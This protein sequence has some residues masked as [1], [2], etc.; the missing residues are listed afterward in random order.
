M[1]YCYFSEFLLSKVNNAGVFYSIPH[2]KKNRASQK[3]KH[4]A[5]K[6]ELR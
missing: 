6:T 3:C 1:N 2:E 5:L 4:N